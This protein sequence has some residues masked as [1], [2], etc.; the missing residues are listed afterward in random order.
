VLVDFPCTSVIL[1]SLWWRHWWHASFKCPKIF[2]PVHLIYATYLFT[3]TRVGVSRRMRIVVIAEIALLLLFILRYAVSTKK[4]QG[5]FLIVT[6]SLSNDVC[7]LWVQRASLRLIM[8]KIFTQASWT[9]SPYSITI[10]NSLPITISVVAARC[11]IMNSIW[12]I[13]LH[14]IA[15]TK[16]KSLFSHKFPFWNDAG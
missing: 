5:L 13:G 11:K 4:L 16:V 2:Y 14:L 3:N 9:C 10:F 1:T 7:D 6:Q 15:P 12:E 8:S